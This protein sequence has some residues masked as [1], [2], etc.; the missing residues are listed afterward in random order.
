[1]NLAA[2]PPA[3]AAAELFGVERGAFTGATQARPGYFALARGGTLFLDEIG[4]APTD[5]QAVLL[6]AIEADEAQ[7]VGAG[8]PQRVDVRLVAAT[9]ADLEAHIRDG[10]FRAP[11][12][13][14]LSAHEIWMPPL[15]DRRDDVARLLL[16]F[17][18]EDLAAA[19]ARSRLSPPAGARPWLPASLVAR[20]VEAEWS[21]NVRQLRNVARQ[22]VAHSRDLDQAALSPAIERMLAAAPPRAPA[23]SAEPRPERRR[24]GEYR[25]DEIVAALRA[26]R[27]ELSPAAAK[28]GISRPALYQWIRKSGR[29]RTAGDLSPDEIARAY[30][31]HGRDA[32]RSALAL[33]VSESALR[34]RIRELGLDEA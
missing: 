12:L 27:W 9:D 3:L 33:E 4:D 14:R 32:A 22:I 28:L 10:R 11:L 26:C 18:R 24:P 34:R 30:R 1:V 15:R 2:V 23:A 19:G 7:A 5:L 16:H 17:L 25:D 21:G 13:H 8:R 29:V 6:R 20:L 31:E